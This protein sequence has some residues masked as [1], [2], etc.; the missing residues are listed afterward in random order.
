MGSSACCG[1]ERFDANGNTNMWD[2]I[3]RALGVVSGAARDG[4]N[5]S[6]FV[7][8]DGQSN[9]GPT[10][11]EVHELQAYGKSKGGFPCSLNMFA[12]GTECNSELLRDL[13]TTTSG[14]YS[15]IPD[16]GFVGTV[17]VNA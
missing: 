1:T 14:M 5:M 11:G 8:T 2:G 9:Q 17:L 12:F 7:L 10:R 6:V 16:S 13:A 15:F 4:K 3:D